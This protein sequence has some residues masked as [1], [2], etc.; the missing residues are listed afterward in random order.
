MAGNGFQRIVKDIKGLKI[1]GASQVRKWAVKALEWSVRQSKAKT[2]AALRKELQRNVATLLKAR[3]TEPELRTSLR[4]FLQRANADFGE[5][6]E[7]RRF[8]LKS[9]GDYEKERA[10]ALKNIAG[11]GLKV[12]FDNAVVFTHCHSHTVEEILALA[13]KAGKLKKV[14]CTETRPAYQGRITA[15]NLAKRGIPVTLVVDGAAAT[16]LKEC[17]FFL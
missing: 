10:S 13:W 14:Y 17:D 3:P 1:Q 9:M 7:L 16:Y 6:Q 2:V 11:N 4:I 8:L 15:A 5:A 12:F